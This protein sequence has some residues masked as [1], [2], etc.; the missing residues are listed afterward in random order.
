MKLKGTKLLGGFNRFRL[1]LTLGVAV[2]LPGGRSYL[3]EFQPG[4]SI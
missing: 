2:L 1:I 4:Q 3:C